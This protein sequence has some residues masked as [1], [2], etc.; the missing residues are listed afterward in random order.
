MISAALGERKPKANTPARVGGRPSDSTICGADEIED[1]LLARGEVS[2]RAVATAPWDGCNFK[3]SRS[4][5]KRNS[6]QQHRRPCS[7]SWRRRSKAPRW[8]PRRAKRD[9]L[10]AYRHPG[11]E[12]EEFVAVAAGA[13]LATETTRRLPHRMS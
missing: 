7:A 8:R 12:G 3:Q 6:G 9:D 4:A 13:R 5:G 11:R 1:F 10:G 2:L